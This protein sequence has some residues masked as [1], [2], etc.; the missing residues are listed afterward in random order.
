MTRGLVAV[1]VASS[2]CAWFGGA[3]SAGE[4]AE[5]WSFDLGSESV[6]E[7]GVLENVYSEPGPALEAIVA[8]LWDR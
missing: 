4:T 1:L 6:P 3:T 2:A 7:L 8:V 5:L